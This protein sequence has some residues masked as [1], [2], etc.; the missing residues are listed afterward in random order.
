MEYIEGLN[1]FLVPINIPTLR[2][3]PSKV[4]LQLLVLYV[5]VSLFLIQFFL[6]FIKLCRNV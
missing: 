3:S 1:M 6:F 4:F 2:F 5:L